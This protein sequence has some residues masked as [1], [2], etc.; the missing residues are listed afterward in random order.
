[1]R[2]KT[3]IQREIHNIKCNKNNNSE[4]KINKCRTFQNMYKEC[5]TGKDTV[6]KQKGFKKKKEMLL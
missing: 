1:M 5:T 4:K 6:E 2:Y 3:Q